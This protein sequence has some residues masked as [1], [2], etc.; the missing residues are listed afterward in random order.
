MNA[1]LAL[2]E[3]ATTAVLTLTEDL[4]RDEFMRSRLT[5]SEVRRRLLLV[6]S[7]LR[8]LGETG[9]RMFPEIDW[10]G[11]SLTAERLEGDATV[12]DD[13][14]W[15]AIRALTPATLTWLRLYRS[16]SPEPIATAS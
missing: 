9:R 7:T 16:L 6:A 5:R 4:E 2:I 14:L 12:A 10:D 11:W 13:A 15:F 8:G 1:A 3:D